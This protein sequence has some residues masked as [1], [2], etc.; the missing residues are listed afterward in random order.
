MFFKMYPFRKWME[1]KVLLPD[2]N[3]AEWCVRVCVHMRVLLFFEKVLKPSGYGPGSSKVGSRFLFFLP[4]ALSTVPGCTNFCLILFSSPGSVCT[5]NSKLCYPSKLGLVPGCVS[6]WCWRASGILP[7]PRHSVLQH[8]WG[9]GCDFSP[10]P[11]NISNNV[12][13]EPLTVV[14]ET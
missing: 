2:W 3:L 5:W 7:S 13:W 8:A 11:T 1:K 10:L 14:P 6:Q 4:L 12:H 9:W